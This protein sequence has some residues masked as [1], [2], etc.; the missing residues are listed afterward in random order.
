M[1]STE[2]RISISVK[3]GKFEISGSEEFVSTQIENF[4]EL[5]TETI[6]NASR[7]VE[8]IKH[9][10]SQEIPEKHIESTEN[11][12]SSSISQYPDIF[13]EDDDSL[14]LVCDIPGSSDSKRTFHA[15][16]L[17]VYGMKLL[18]RD[19]AI[20][21]EIREICK[22]HGCYDSANFSSHIKYGDPRYYLDKGSGKTRTLKLNRPGEK[23][24]EKLIQQITENAE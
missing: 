11:N 8:S 22:N 16:L 10:N 12:D 24:A 23:E 19:E 4:K 17:Y 6:K 1:D 20:V 3:E 5:I 15:A 18:G 9:P 7:K 14:R 13:V 2:S 21:E